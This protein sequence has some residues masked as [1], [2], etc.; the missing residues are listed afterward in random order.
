MN[1]GIVIQRKKD[2][3]STWNYGTIE[4]IFPPLDQRSLQVVT[5]AL[6]GLHGIG[7]AFTLI[8]VE[9]EAIPPHIRHPGIPS[10]RGC[11]ADSISSSNDDTNFTDPFSWILII[12]ITIQ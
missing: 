9:A 8:K 4:K 5:S 11:E 6:F 10:I 7:L 12:V 3:E 2:I 1:R